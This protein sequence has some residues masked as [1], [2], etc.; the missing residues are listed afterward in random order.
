VSMV[1]KSFGVLRLHG[2]DV[3]FSLPRSDSAGRKPSVQINPFMSIKEAFSRRDLTINAMGI[4]LVTHELIDPFGG[5]EDI[6]KKI[7]RVPDK[8]KFVEDP[9]RFY[10]VMQFISRFEMIPDGQLNEICKSMDIS[11]ISTERIETEFNKLMLK[12][13][14][15]SLGLRW[16]KELS[17]LREVLP[18]VADIVDIP[19]EHDWHPEGDVFEHLM[20]CIDAA[21]AMEYEGDT[22]KL[23]VMYATLCHDLGKAITTEN[24]GGKWKSIGHAKKGV[25][26]AKNLLSKFTRNKDLAEAVEKM[27]RHH[28]APLQFVAAKAKPAAY[29]RL[30][31]KLAPHTTLELL[32]K[33]SLADR[34]GRNP[35]KGAPLAKTFIVPAIENFLKKAKEAH[36]EKIPEPPVLLGRDIMD[37]VEPGPLMGEILKKAYEIQIEK[38]IQD[39][40][41]LKRIVL[42]EIALEK[43]KNEE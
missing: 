5:C 22:D 18:E 13:A 6:H 28:M 1:G 9:L 7:L 21:A 12:S 10:R 29:K 31:R 42:D 25:R 34:R 24:I 19:Q 8:D 37:A 40:Q 30:A 39:T 41:E 33:V 35:I 32:A 2:L 26:I 3:D 16:L 14:K 23:K 36:V 15:P 4:D 17:R 43:G 11:Q 38:G 20:Q 27:V